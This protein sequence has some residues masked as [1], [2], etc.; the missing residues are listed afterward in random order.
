MDSAPP[1]DAE[2]AAALAATGHDT[3]ATGLTL[4]MLA[5][6]RNALVEE[7]PSVEKLAEDGTFEITERAVPG[8][9][10]APD[11]SL[12]ILRPKGLADARP[13][14][15][16]TH[17]GGLIM[18]NNR[19]GLGQV[20]DWALQ[21]GLVVVS[22]EY[23]LAPEHPF[24]AA[25]DD[26]YAGLLWTARNA[27][28][29]G[30]DPRRVIVA[31]GSA[32]GN[33]AAGLSLRARDQ[34]GI[35]LL[36]QVLIYPMLDDRS[37]T[38]SAHQMT[39]RG[40]WDRVSNETAWTA[41]LGAPHPREEVPGYAAPAR[42]ADLSGLPA[43]YLEV[44]TAETFRDEVIAFAERIWSVGGEAELH[45]WPGAFHGFDIFA[46]HAALSQD[47]REARLRWLKR[48]LGE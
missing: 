12:L 42:A 18:G 48:L 13:I 29:I 20:T 15:Y 35:E 45:V 33:L 40:V 4:D 30:G 41:V 17:G 47:A 11:V 24:P 7:V 19:F 38:L 22:V 28:S 27:E 3:F 1:F 26:A 46:P 43:A 36:G 10:G 5:T 14:V 2:L 6:E 37:E 9:E 25:L 32:G 23:R 44:G 39:G 34:G 31:G 21:L 16:H 8:L